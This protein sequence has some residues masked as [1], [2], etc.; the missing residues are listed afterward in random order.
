[1]VPIHPASS[2]SLGC[3]MGMGSNEERCI[4][5]LVMVGGRNGQPRYMS[6]RRESWMSVGLC[7]GT[8]L[9]CVMSFSCPH[10]SECFPWTHKLSPSA[11]KFRPG[12]P[13]CSYAWHIPLLPPGFLCAYKSTHA[14]VQHGHGVWA[15]LRREAMLLPTHQASTVSGVPALGLHPCAAD[16]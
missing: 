10:T 6:G 7:C 14:L 5:C 8:S 15:A 2:T 9:T 13:L 16:E 3:A 1:M 12:G 11:V 4:L